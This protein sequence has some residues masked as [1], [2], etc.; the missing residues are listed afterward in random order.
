MYAAAVCTWGFLAVVLTV[1][2]VSPFASF[3]HNSRGPGRLRPGRL[4]GVGA[5]CACLLV[6]VVSVVLFRG[7]VP[8]VFAFLI[9]AVGF[10]G[11]LLPGR[12]LDSD[13][14]APAEGGAAER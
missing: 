3:L 4:L 2:S 7:P 14:P 12:L 9:V 6:A 5:A 10:F 1:A 8:L 11:L 13:A